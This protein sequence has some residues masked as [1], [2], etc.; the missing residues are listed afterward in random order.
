MIYFNEDMVNKRLSLLISQKEMLEKT[1]EQMLRICPD[2]TAILNVLKEIEDTDKL[3]E[4]CNKRKEIIDEEFKSCL[5]D[6]PTTDK[7]EMETYTGYDKEILSF[8]LLKS[9]A[10]NRRLAKEILKKDE[11]SN[12]QEYKTKSYFKEGN[13][14]KNAKKDN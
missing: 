5:D 14:F 3:I 11:T 4:I 13:V 12:K 1:Y 10:L 8:L 9:K 2:D 6:V 7:D